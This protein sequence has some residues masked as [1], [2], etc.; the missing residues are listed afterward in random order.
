MVAEAM[1]LPGGEASGKPLT[2]LAAVSSGV[3]RRQQFEIVLAYW[4]LAQGVAEYHYCL[5]HAKT[6]DSFGAFAGRA[7]DDAAMLAARADAAAQVQEAQLGLLR[8]QYELAAVGRSPA[9]TPLPLPA[10]RPH[11]GP[12]RTEF[13]ALFADRTPPEPARLADRI[14]PVQQ[15][16]I[17]QQAAAMQAAEDALAAV[18]EDHRSGR[19]GG[20]AV[21]SCS[22]E[23]LRQQRAFIRAVGEYNRNIADYRFSVVGPAATPQE[24]VGGLILTADT[25]AARPLSGDGKA[26]RPASAEEPLHPETFR[27]QP[28]GE[29]TPAPPRDE[30][31]GSAGS[32][33]PARLQ[34]VGT[35]EP[36]LAPPAAGTSREPADIP[37]TRVVPIESQ[38]PATD[39]FQRS[40][41]PSADSSPAPPSGPVLRTAR[42]LQRPDSFLPDDG[43]RGGQYQP[44]PRSA[45]GD[46]G[47]RSG[48]T[49]ARY[50]ALAA[51]LPAARTRQLTATLYGD[52]GVPE[53]AGKPIALLDC[54][55]RNASSDRLTT[56][57]AYWLLRQRQAQFRNLLEQQ[58]MLA[59]IEPVVMERRTDATGPADMLRL[60][61]AKLAAKAAIFQAQVA[62]IEAQYALALRIGI[63]AEAAWPLASTAPH[64][65]S[66]SLKIESQ[67][68]G[69]IESWP[70]RRLT[71]II[72][73][74]TDTVAGLAA[75]VVEADSA[76]AAAIESYRFG[77]GGIEAVLEGV[78]GQTEETSTLLTCVTDYNAAI[79]EY[80]LAVLPPGYPADKLVASLV[81]KP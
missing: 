44:D 11:V 58:E 55:F 74:L 67:P 31:P 68:R 32:D 79:A 35:G 40:A 72:P 18:D 3:D 25:P 5:G 53:G 57:K 4:R 51:A 69:I 38:A 15:Q 14:L 39:P 22:R 63:V 65:S 78:T 73:R 48:A 66:Y 45:G 37:E 47:G 17:V 76:R 61:T 52:L 81:T 7:A 42:K 33:P 80:S 19:G 50:A 49:G 20:G 71:A 2:L 24:L 70:V 13:K 26:V 21:I 59:A 16:Q 43:A 23:L 1:L 36:H 54:L 77:R 62:L 6:L 34:P 28:Q 9:G 30:P 56:I 8:A 75:A 10:D 29:P 27:R 46:S 60:Q 41:P 12:Y 64:S